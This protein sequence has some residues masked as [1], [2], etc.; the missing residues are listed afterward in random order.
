MTIAEILKDGYTVCHPPYM[1]DQRSY[2]TYQCMGQIGT[3][4]A[5]GAE[6]ETGVMYSV[7]YYTDTPPF[8]LAIRISR[9]GSLRQAGVALW[10]RKYTK[11]TRDC[12]T[13]P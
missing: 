8:E 5:E 7:D 4:Y 1:G 12:T 6:K 11:W 9:A 13:L 3:L 10:T 2:I